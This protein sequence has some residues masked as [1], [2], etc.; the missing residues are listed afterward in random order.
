[1]AKTT[2]LGLNLTEDTQTAFGTWRSSI[3]GVGTGENKSNMQIIDEF[4][5]S[6]PGVSGSVTLVS[7]SWS[8]K[9]Y[10]LSVAELGA[11]DM[12]VLTPATVT[13]QERLN[14]ARVFVTAVE[15]Q[16]TITAKVQPLQDIALKYFIVRG[17]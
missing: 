16:V 12:I 15:G 1:M 3:D 4:A 7:S 5:G 2:N 6:I 10:T 11:N 17:K 8:N 13:D 9:V 14:D